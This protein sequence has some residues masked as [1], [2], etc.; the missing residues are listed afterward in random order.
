MRVVIGTNN[1]PPE[2]QAVQPKA[3]FWSLGSISVSELFAAVGILG[4]MVGLVVGIVG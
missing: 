2:M 3:G 1:E 4:I